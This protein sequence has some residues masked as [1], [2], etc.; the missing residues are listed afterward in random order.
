MNTAE[1]TTE[2]PADSGPRPF[3]GLRVIDMTHVLAGPFSTHQLAM[4]GADVIKVEGPN[5]PDMTRA[6][7]AVPELN[8]EFYGTYFMAQNSGK[9]GL[10]A[11]I[12][13]PEGRE[14]I[15]R[16]AAGAD[17]MV[18]NYRAGKLAALGLGYDDIRA[19]NPRIIYC[20]LTGFGQT[21][22]KRAHPAYDTVIQAFSGI[23]TANGEKD[24]P[25]VRVGPP[26]VD[27]GTGAQAAYAVAAA[28][29]Q[30]EKTGRGQRI[31]VAMA[32]A[33][34]MMQSVTAAAVQAA[35]KVQLGH[36]NAH[37]SYAGYSAYETA[38]GGGE[39]LMIGAWTN[40]QMGA[41]YRAAGDDA[42][43]VRAENIARRDVGTLRDDDAAFLRREMRKKTADEWEK[44]LND[45]GV[46][47]ARVRKIDE[48]M[49]SAQAASRGVLQTYEG[50][51]RKGAPKALPAAAF[52]YDHG[53]PAITRPPPRLGEHTAEILAELGYADGEIAALKE[54]GVV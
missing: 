47:A 21:G 3:E 5:A 42:R 36:G 37:P 24:A 23:M 18:E 27:Y 15:K 43:A 46:P 48:T 40:R 20:S 51:D 38:G 7:G 33:A 35:G 26:M 6:E 50:A 2:N 39:M 52:M 53:G 44:I 22:P 31:D 11:D 19:L 41:L 8:E 49:A 10:T 28:L 17:V 32:D 45:A 30:R 13:T 25:P 16:L 9:R 4:L 34:L 1:N 29:F 54:K 12:K 14:I